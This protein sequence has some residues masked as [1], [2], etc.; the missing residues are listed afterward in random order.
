MKNAD[1]EV[2]DVTDTD[3][4]EID[5]T[6]GAHLIHTE[7]K[8]CCV[9]PPHVRSSNPEVAGISNGTNSFAKHKI[10][11]LCSNKV[12]DSQSCIPPTNRSV[13]VVSSSSTYSNSN[14]N[15]DKYPCF[16][17]E[18]INRQNTD[19]VTVTIGNEGQL[20]KLDAKG[21]SEQ[22]KLKEAWQ[23]RV[24]PTRKMVAVKSVISFVTGVVFGIAIQKGAGKNYW[25]IYFSHTLICLTGW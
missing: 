14:N 20:T 18:D 3:D 22:D 13:F 19:I 4:G 7:S 23:Q 9:T 24:E 12:H 8:T 15:A 5:S 16:N 6:P 21:Q 10:P 2:K 1:I 25:C 11:L 17:T